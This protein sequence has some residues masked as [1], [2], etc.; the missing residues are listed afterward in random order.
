MYIEEF[1]VF[2]ESQTSGCNTLLQKEIKNLKNQLQT[3]KYIT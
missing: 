1:K 2:I 3:N